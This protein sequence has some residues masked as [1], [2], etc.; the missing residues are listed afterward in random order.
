M[1]PTLLFK[2]AATSSPEGSFLNLVETPVL[3]ITQA[4]KNTTASTIA[5]IPF[6]VSTF[7]TTLASQDNPQSPFQTLLLLLTSLHNAHF[8][9]TTLSV[10]SII[11]LLSA[12]ALKRHTKDKRIHA[13]PEILV[14]VVVTTLLTMAFRWDLSG[15]AILSKISASIP[16][17]TPTFPNPSLAKI[18][19]LLLSAVL[20]SVIGFVE[21]IV[22]AK[23]YAAKHRYGVSPNRELVAMG[24]GNIFVG[25][26]GGFPAY[27]SLGRSAVADAAGAKTQMAGLVTALMVFLTLF[28]L[29]L[30]HYLPKAVCSCII[31]VAA[32][33]LIEVDEIRFMWRCRAYTDLGL[34][35]VTFGTTVF[36]GIE[37]GT[38]LSVG[39][40]LLMVIK[41][42]TT[43]RLVLLGESSVID[44]GFG[45][46]RI[47]YRNI[48]EESTMRLEGILIVRFEE[49]L[50]FGNVGQLKDR[51]KRVEEHGDLGVHP[52]EAPREGYVQWDDQTMTAGSSGR[53]DG[54]VF[55]M[56]A[57]SDV[58]ARYF[59]V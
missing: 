58:D 12:K 8:L 19:H 14:L 16:A 9:S 4:I 18:K 2:A 32:L 43:T 30:F 36:V 37:T 25:M 35:A 45:G 28:I 48:R 31:V 27:G 51:L 15:L 33:G 56:K 44:N 17:T 41:H 20:I 46:T 42:T 53:L 3:I 29:P 47:K 10:C 55:D 1:T 59:R 39:I 23:T 52:G 7:K 40:S 13:I 11:W 54:V 5:L 26:A 21:S 38:L 57:V 6:T 22:V 49:G 34:V 50:F 24:V